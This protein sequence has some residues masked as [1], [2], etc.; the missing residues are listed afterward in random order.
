MPDALLACAPTDSEDSRARGGDE[1]AARHTPSDFARVPA[2]ND[3]NTGPM[4]GSHPPVPAPASDAASDAAPA[5]M[6]RYMTVAEA[7]GLFR[8]NVKTAYRWALEGRLPG[9]F[10]L[11]GSEWRVCREC[12]LRYVRENSASSPGET[13]R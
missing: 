13:E 7:A 10:R 8:I 2:S 1:V 9:A 6:P 11:G 4:P 12:L 3:A 5:E